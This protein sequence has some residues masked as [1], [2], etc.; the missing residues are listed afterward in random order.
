MAKT[1]NKIKTDAPEDVGCW[2]ES[3]AMGDDCNC[4]EDAIKRNADREKRRE[5]AQAS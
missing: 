5:L 1:L 3:R 4:I 2:C